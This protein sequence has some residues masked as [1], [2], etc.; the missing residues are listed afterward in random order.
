MK[1]FLS[2]N[3]LGL[4]CAM[5][6]AVTSVYQ[7]RA[8][9]SDTA[10]Y[11]NGDNYVEIQNSTDGTFDI[12]SGPFTTEAWIRVDSVPDLYEQTIISNNNYYAD[13]GGFRLTVYPTGELVIQYGLGSAAI[14]EE[15]NVSDGTCHHVAVIRNSGG[16]MQ[17]VVDGE[18]YNSTSSTES[19][20]STLPLLIGMGYD[21]GNENQ[22]FTPFYGAIKEIRFWNTARTLQQ[23]QAN[24]DN[25]LSP[26]TGLIGYWRMN[27]GSGTLINDYS[28]SNKDGF[29]LESLWA[30]GCAPSGGNYVTIPDPNF[31]TWLQNNGYAACMNGNLMDTTCPAVV[32]AY[33]IDCSGN[34]ISDLTGIQY[35][36]NLYELACGYNN[37]TELP[38]L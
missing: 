9:I 29:A 37:L 30:T 12:G 34:N 3:A 33:S 7:S 27:E 18:L 21:G 16:F 23:I 2:T 32:N 6:L 17:F 11:F 25:A 35:F 36:D 14:L 26:Q 28:M 8:Q 5:I 38:Q 24:V 1:P 15:V 19:I 31:V 4:A 13:A 10:L 22:L 20:T